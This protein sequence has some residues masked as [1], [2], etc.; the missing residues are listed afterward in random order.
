M[1]QKEH[2][3]KVKQKNKF[4]YSFISPNLNFFFYRMKIKMGEIISILQK[5]TDEIN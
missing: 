1:L 3:F 4:F 2:K 5:E